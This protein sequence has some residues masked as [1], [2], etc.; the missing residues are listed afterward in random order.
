MWCCVKKD[1]M[2]LC[3]FNQKLFTSTL[4]VVLFSVFVAF[5]AAQKQDQ[6]PI[7]IVRYDNEGVN[8]DG[9]YQWR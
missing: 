1:F 3:R 5:C 8:A 9:S 4:Q 2:V 6:E 7:A